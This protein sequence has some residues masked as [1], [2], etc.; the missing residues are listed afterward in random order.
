M[1]LIRYH[2]ILHG[3]QM[4]QGMGTASL[5]AKLIQH[6]TEMREEVLYEVF[7]DLQKVYKALDRDLCT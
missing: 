4:V 6:M 3:L 5:K 7:I 1:T 2:D